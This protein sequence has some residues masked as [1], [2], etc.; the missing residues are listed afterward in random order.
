MDQLLFVRTMKARRLLGITI[1]SFNLVWNDGFIG[2]YKHVMGVKVKEEFAHDAV[3]LAIA[4]ELMA[5]QAFS[6]LLVG[7]FFYSS[8]NFV[9]KILTAEIFYDEQFAGEEH[10]QE[11]HDKFLALMQRFSNWMNRTEEAE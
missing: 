11:I 3:L 9:G 4:E 5:L 10:K 8:I 2:T 7:K 1:A 6:R